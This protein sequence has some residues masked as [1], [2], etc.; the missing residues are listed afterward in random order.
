M[1]H[2]AFIGI[3]SNLGDRAVHYHKA[4]ERV[5]ALP[6][7][8][9]IRQSSV[10]ETDPVGDIKGAFLNGVIEIETA[11]HPKAL[12]HQLLNIEHAMG[13]RRSPARKTGQAPPEP[14]TID[15][16]LLFFDDEIIDMPDLVLPH[17]RLHERHF[18]LV[19]IAELAPMLTHPKLNKTITELRSELKVPQRVTMLRA[20]AQEALPSRPEVT[21]E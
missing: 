7:T 1:P 8:R 21:K 18:V 6:N 2:R 19:P 12:L 13:R 4:I 15:L 17:P 9:V 16:D 3:G 5:A 10:Y 11:S 20:E 14:R